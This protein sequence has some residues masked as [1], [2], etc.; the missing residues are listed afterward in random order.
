MLCRSAM[1][2]AWIAFWIWFATFANAADFFWAVQNSRD[3]GSIGY[4]PHFPKCGDSCSDC[5][6]KAQACAKSNICYEPESEET[7]CGDTKGTSCIQGYYCAFDVD[8][9]NVA[10]CCQEGSDLSE[11]EE[12]LTKSLISSETTIAPD[13]TTVII[14]MTPTPTSSPKSTSKSTITKVSSSTPSETEAKPASSS[15]GPSIRVK[16]GVSVGAVG[17]AAFLFAI[18]LICMRR[19][20]NRK[21]TKINNGR[22]FTPLVTGYDPISAP[23][24]TAPGPFEP[25]RQVSTASSYYT[26]GHEHGDRISLH[27]PAPSRS[28]SP[29]GVSDGNFVPTPLSSPTPIQTSSFS[30]PSLG[31]PQ[32]HHSFQ[33]HSPDEPSHH[34]HSPHE[35]PPDE[36]SDEHSADEHSTDEHSGDDHSIDERYPD[37]HSFHDHS[38]HDDSPRGLNVGF[39]ISRNSSPDSDHSNSPS[40]LHL[41]NLGYSVTPSFSPLPRE[42]SHGTHSQHPSPVLSPPP[43]GLPNNRHSFIIPPVPAPFLSPHPQ[44]LPNNRH[45]YTYTA[46]PVPVPSPA[47]AHSPPPQELPNNGYMPKFAVELPSNELST[48]QSMPPGPVEL[49]GVDDRVHELPSSNY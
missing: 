45:S 2:S 41:P 11:C 46:R 6:E 7:C 25:M 37:E 33:D 35:H 29:P 23:E 27:L 43:Q 16:V 44:A 36:H 4:E 21:Y 10:Y 40:G 24:Y 5:E 22:G 42:P 14:T 1:L 39:G 18:I 9:D 3:N 17:G 15:T 38:P 28:P 34:E 31:S 26:I 8:A 13:T 12:V 19:R 49:P 48:V 20:R 30:V 32:D 47:L